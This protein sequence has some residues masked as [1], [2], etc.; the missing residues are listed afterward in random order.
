MADTFSLTWDATGSRYYETGISRGV[1]Y[2]MNSDGTY[3]DGVAWDGLTGWD[4]N[5]DGAEINTLWADNIKYAQFQTPEDHKGNIKAY[6]YPDEFDECNGKKS[7]SDLAGMVFGEQKRRAFGACYR[8]ELGT[9][10]DP[11]KG[12]VLHIVYNSR[13]KPSSISHATKNENPDA[14]EMS[15]D[16]ESTPVEVTGVTGISQT[17][18]IE[19]DSTVLTA[20]QMLAAEKLLYGFGN[21]AAA[22]PTPGALYTAIKAAV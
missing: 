7:P 9:D 10:T 22:L 21:V 19:L 3:A 5:P 2:P 4:E 11:N 13:I 14:V 17:S 18:T 15:W 12:Y 16:Y 8:T 6:M 1:I 20:A